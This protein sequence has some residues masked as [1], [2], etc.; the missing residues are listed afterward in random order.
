MALLMISA[1]TASGCAMKQQGLLDISI[2]ESYCQRN[3][4]EARRQLL[5]GCGRAQSPVQIQ[6]AAQRCLWYAHSTFRK[7][8]AKRCGQSRSWIILLHRLPS[9]SQLKQAKAS[10]QMAQ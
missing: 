10:H 6:H 4:A 9:V 5:P 3:M 1:T 8:K 2:P 7:R